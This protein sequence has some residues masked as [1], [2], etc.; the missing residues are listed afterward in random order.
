MDPNV[1]Q[2]QVALHHLAAAL[3]ILDKAEEHL[4][5][6]QIDHVINKFQ[7]RTCS[8]ASPL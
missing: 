4:A 8:E 6:A 2:T 7:S 1:T 5:A 3:V